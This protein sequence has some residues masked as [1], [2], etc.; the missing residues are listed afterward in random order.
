M[1]QAYPG[2]T[3]Q[4]VHQYKHKLN[5]AMNLFLEASFSIP[6]DYSTATV[7]LPQL[8]A[9]FWIRVSS[10]SAS[11]S[12]GYLP[13][14]NGKITTRNGNLNGHG[15]RSSNKLPEVFF[16]PYCVNI[17]I[18]HNCFRPFYIIP[19]LAYYWNILKLTIT[20]IYIYDIY[21]YI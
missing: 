20:Y 16:R 13:V 7:S 21:I 4:Q 12:H 6:C 9:R 18:Y 17:Y 14:C 3:K 15:F 10:L 2:M 5:C 19:Y 1:S 8:N 11:N